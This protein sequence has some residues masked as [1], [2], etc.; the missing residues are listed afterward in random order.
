MRA[1]KLTLNGSASYTVPLGNAG[2]IELAADARYNSLQY[3]YVTPQDTVNRYALNQPG[4]TIA[5][6]RISY[7]AAN[8]RYTLSVSPSTICSTRIIATTRCR[9]AIRRRASTAT[10]CSG[11]IRAPT[12]SRS[13]RDSDERRPMRKKKKKKK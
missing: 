4:Y 7:S 5:N 2:S 11:A 1:P 10:R 9:R 12:A 6:A 3:Y 8:D 13:S